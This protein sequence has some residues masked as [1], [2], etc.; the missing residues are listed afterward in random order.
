MPEVVDPKLQ[1][2][3]RESGHRQERHGG[4]QSGYKVKANGEAGQERLPEP[5]K[6][7][8]A[9][10]LAESI[11]DANLRERKNLLVLTGKS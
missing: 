10:S 7:T 8:P 5:M 9:F 1:G 2:Q 3:E 6:T 11:K 4:V